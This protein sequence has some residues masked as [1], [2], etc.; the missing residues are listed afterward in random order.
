MKYGKL[1]STIALL[2]ALAIP[3]SLAA[4]EHP[5][6]HHKYNLVDIGTFG[7][8]NVSFNFA[9]PND[10]LLGSN[11]KV[12]GGADTTTVDPDCFDS[13]DCFL[14]HAFKWQEGVLNDLG[15]LPGGTGN[16]SSQAF[17]INDRGQTVGLSTNGTKEPLTG[18]LVLHAVLWS[19]QGQIQDLG[20]FGGYDSYAAAINRSGQVVG[21]AANATPDP[22]ALFLL[23][24]QV[25]AFLWDKKTGMQD[26]GTLGTGNDAFATFVN[27][28]GQVAG[29]AYTNTTPNPVNNLCGQLQFGLGV[30]TVDPFFWENGTI[31]DIGT[32]GGVC[33]YAMG[34]NNRGQVIGDSDVVGDVSFHGFRWDKKRGLQDLLPL[35]GIYSG[36]YGIN[37]AGDA[38]GWADLAG[39]LTNDAVIWPNGSTTPIDLGLTA[40]FTMSL[41][42]ATNSKGQIVGCLTSD[43]SSICF[44]YNSDSFLWEN[45]DMVDVNAL[46][47]P[48]PGVRLSGSEGYINDQGEIVLLGLLDNGD[49]HAFLLSPCDDNHRDGGNCGERAER[50]T[51]AALTQSPTEENPPAS[52]MI[53]GLHGRLGRRYPY[54]GFGTDQRK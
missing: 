11:G 32:L 49:V 44:P 27:D 24:Q 41:A 4:Q 15:A 20:T 13:P 46:V 47:P 9:S 43:P 25:R 34:L 2:V 35:G 52:S 30:P 14:E 6:K 39:D 50:A 45:G 19:T 16:N 48:H 21:L 54:R 37:D 40:G 22:N 29:Y 51:A 53:G 5:A 10:H 18:H 33:G 17:W 3:V 38:V 31:T 1:I 36:T 8:P 7:G 28:R 42:E 12:T 26:L 23:G